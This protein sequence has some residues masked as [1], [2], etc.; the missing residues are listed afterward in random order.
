MF[1][2]IRHVGATPTEWKRRF[3]SCLIGQRYLNEFMMN[4]SAYDDMH[5]WF[6][7]ELRLLVTET[8]RIHGV[9]KHVR[10]TLSSKST[11][12]VS[13]FPAPPNIS[14]SFA[15]AMP[16]SAMKRPSAATSFALDEQNV[17]KKPCTAGGIGAKLR[18]A[19]DITE[20]SLKKLQG[21]SV[22]KIA[23]FLENFPA[24]EQQRLWKQYQTN[25]LT[26][27]TD[28]VY[29]NLTNVP[30]G[31]KM[32]KTMLKIWISGGCTTK[33]QVY[34]NHLTKISDTEHKGSKAI[35]QPL[36]MMIT[37]Y[38]VPE[39][40]ARVDSGS[41][42]VRRNEGD[43][44]FPEFLDVSQYSDSRTT[45]EK[46]KDI[47]AK[48][49][50]DWSDFNCLANIANKRQ[51]LQFQEGDDTHADE[52]SVQIAFGAGKKG[53][54]GADAGPGKLSLDWWPAGNE[55]DA[56]SGGASGSGATPP[57]KAPSLSG[58]QSSSIL[59][60]IA[61]AKFLA[62]TKDIDQNKLMIAVLKA[63]GA[64]S[65]VLGQLEQKS[66]GNN[67]FKKQCFGKIGALNSH[68]K[69]FEKA[70]SR[71]MKAAAVKQL[72]NKAATIAKSCSKL[73]DLDN[74]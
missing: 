41:I 7:R 4:D 68:L 65:T 52:S 3:R 70:A 11:V 5:A 18:C 46:S 61:D 21:Q 15:T 13:D 71:N 47:Q 2:E 53:T 17:M 6:R 49:K 31:K 1:S 69:A 12:I 51:R 8:S 25:R 56:R 29:R 40:K 58:S 72:V 45:T 22:D 60:V 14:I 50:A 28:D 74:D 34:Q 24:S 57:L 37:K 16:P 42:K 64:C 19:E 62:G 10:T 73:I 48:G 63:K 43:P 59:K 27:G 55:E 33:G 66:V 26:E 30:G 67:K 9:Y 38:G 35:W 54:Q 39:L 36:Q 32:S 20:A 44:R 23:T